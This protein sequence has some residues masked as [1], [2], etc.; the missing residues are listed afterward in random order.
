MRMKQIFFSAVVFIAV[1]I[2]CGQV[3]GQNSSSNDNVTVPT[4]SND[5]PGP[6]GQRHS[7]AVQ[8]AGGGWKIKAGCCYGME[9]CFRMN[10]C[11]NRSFSC[12]GIHYH[13][14]VDERGGKDDF[15][16]KP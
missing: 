1:G 3:I 15:I 11:D 2:F 4:Y 8:C 13:P 16:S 5:G 14:F 12:D 10:P 7:Q 6:Q 9:D